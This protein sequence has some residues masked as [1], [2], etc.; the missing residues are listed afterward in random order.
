MAK[1]QVIFYSAPINT[2]L[3]PEKLAVLVRESGNKL[4]FGDIYIFFNRQRDRCKV[5]WHDG[6]AYCS[7]EKLLERGT[8]APNDK[9]KISA[10][11][12]ENFL[13]G[14]MAGHVELLHALMGNVAYINDA[15]KR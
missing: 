5:V 3:S 15:R 12:I 2:R 10:T 14:G 7:V 9:I 4:A 6:D 13:Y 1:P 8:F 11:A